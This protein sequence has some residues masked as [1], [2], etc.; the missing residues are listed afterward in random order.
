MLP[1][2]TV[3]T[4]IDFSTV[5]ERYRKSSALPKPD[6]VSLTTGKPATCSFALFPYP[7]NLANDGRRGDTTWFSPRACRV[8]GKKPGA[9]LMMCQSI[10]GSDVFGPVRF[11]KCMRRGFRFPVHPGYEARPRRLLP[12]REPGKLDDRRSEVHGLDEM[13]DPDAVRDNVFANLAGADIDLERAITQLPVQAR[14]VFVLH[15][16]EGYKHTDIA[17]MLGLSPHTSRSQLHRARMLLRGFL[18]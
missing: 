8:P 16:V 10:T 14:M 18:K 2:V 13:R 12:L 7:A 5:I 3:C 11:G 6:A 15:D 4:G 17:E 9:V 1:Q